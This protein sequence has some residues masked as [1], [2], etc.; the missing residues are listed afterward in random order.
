LEALGGLVT[1]EC[2]F[3]IG[4]GLD[5][6]AKPVCVS[7]VCHDSGKV[8][9][10]LMTFECKKLGYECCL[11]CKCVCYNGMVIRRECEKFRECSEAECP[12][13]AVHSK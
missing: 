4:F 5:Q 2:T 3:R 6:K 10:H 11:K 7:T 12:E 13:G 9:K 1:V 8:Y